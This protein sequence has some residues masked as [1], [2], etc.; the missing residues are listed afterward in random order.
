MTE[1][2]L[3]STRSLERLIDR[4]VD[5][6]LTPAELGEAIRHL[7][8]TSNG[9]RRCGL[10]F[11][12]AQCWRESFRDLGDSIDEAEYDHVSFK[13][14]LP[15]VDAIEKPALALMS[16][17]GRWVGSALAAGIALVAFT[18]GWFGHGLKISTSGSNP[19]S[20]AAASEATRSTMDIDKTAEPS[21]DEPRQP[22][23]SSFWP[24][25]RVPT[26]REVARLRIETGAKT[27]AEIPILTGPG[28]TQRWLSEQPPPISEHNQAVWQSRGYQVDQRRQ[29]LSFQLG[30]GRQ[31]AVPVDHVQL[32]YVGQEPL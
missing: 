7:D 9:W 3:D 32:R 12:E 13:S 21:V 6:G 4:I 18:L 26:V 24:E 25:N 11:L 22:A 17:A 19:M 16:P 14:E 5:G 8:S 23:P 1:D 28:M 15:R 29:V 2:D 31:A 27:P 10:A 30:D 20:V